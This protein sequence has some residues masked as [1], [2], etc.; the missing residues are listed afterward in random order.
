MSLE[1]AVN[2][3]EGFCGVQEKKENEVSLKNNW[4]MVIQ[5]DQLVNRINVKYYQ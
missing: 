2:F 1:E 4:G 5:L 3:L